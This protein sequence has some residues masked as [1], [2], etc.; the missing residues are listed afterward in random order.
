MT[1]HTFLFAVIWYSET[2]QGKKL[3]SFEMPQFNW[4]HNLINATTFSIKSQR[5]QINDWITWNKV[6]H[7]SETNIQ[8]FFSLLLHWW[9]RITTDR[10]YFCTYLVW[11][12][13]TKDRG[14]VSEE[15]VLLS[16]RKFT[17]LTI[18]NRIANVRVYL[19]ITTNCCVIHFRSLS[20]ID[21]LM[22]GSIKTIF[23]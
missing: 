10:M 16:I 17:Q 18:Y 15:T 19:L 11:K 7:F 2:K 4:C 5:L 12:E 1:W 20:Y 3:N 21:I 8:I 9:N 22:M 6:L 14:H 13:R 23:S